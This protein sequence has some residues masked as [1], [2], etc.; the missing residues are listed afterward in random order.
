MLT[1]VVDGSFLDMSTIPEYVRG[2]QNEP[3]DVRAQATMRGDPVALRIVA[4]GP[5]RRRRGQENDAGQPEGHPTSRL[6]P[7]LGRS[8][9]RTRSP[10]S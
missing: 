1:S 3:A 8:L 5:S 6:A 9:S 10:S 2:T 7:T 4:L